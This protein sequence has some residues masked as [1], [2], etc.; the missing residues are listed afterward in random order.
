MFENSVFN[1][2]G[3][4]RKQESYHEE[5]IGDEN[6]EQQ[7]LVRV[8]KNIVYSPMR[9]R[10]IDSSVISYQY[11]NCFNYSLLSREGESIKLTLGVTSARPGEGKTLVA[12]NL[13]MSLTL[14][15][16][17][18]TVLVDLNVQ[19]PKL[20][21]IFGVPISPGVVEALNGTTIHVSQTQVDD[22][23]ILSAGTFRGMSLAIEQQTRQALNKQEAGKV[24]A[25]GLEQMAAFRDMVYSLSQEFEF[26]IVDLPA[27]NSRS[28]PSLFVNQLMGLVGVIDTRVTKREDI[29]EMFKVVNQRQVLGFVLNRVPENGQ[30]L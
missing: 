12:S 7:K 1:E 11:Y 9:G 22:L 24:P 16:Q 26:V 3:P 30:A 5:D 13:A 27:L 19:R 6:V 20:H 29:E 17:E 28:F 21:E 15:Y 8:R 4:V 2:H 10:R 18:K 25:I 23:Y 14:A